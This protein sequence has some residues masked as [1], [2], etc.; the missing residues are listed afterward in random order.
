MSPPAAAAQTGSDTSAQAA[1]GSHSL[2]VMVQ[3][4]RHK[5]TPRRRRPRPSA[6]WT[7]ALQLQV[8]ARHQ[9]RAGA[10]PQPHVQTPRGSPA[11]APIGPLLISGKVHTMVC[12]NMAACCAPW[13]TERRPLALPA[14]PLTY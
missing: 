9:P 12:I 6:P 13:T 10:S 2:C 3:R 5:T 1:R 11:R 4:N 7:D 14:R 8:H